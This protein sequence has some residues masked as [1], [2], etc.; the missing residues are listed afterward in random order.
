MKD[1]RS[2]P[3]A[4]TAAV[5]YPACGTTARAW[6]IFAGSAFAIA[7]AAFLVEATGLL[8][9]SPE[10]LPTGAG[11]VADEATFHAAAFTYAQQVL[12]GFVLRDGSYFFAYLALIP[13][14]LG[15]REVAGRRGVAPQLAAAFLG[16]AA[17]FGCRAARSILRSRR[18]ANSS[19]MA[20]ASALQ[21][22]TLVDART[23]R[24]TSMTTVSGVGQRASSSAVR[25]LSSISQA[26]SRV[27]KAEWRMRNGSVHDRIRRLTSPTL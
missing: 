21:A 7:T 22:A 10:Y 25:S 27:W 9:S 6:G 26:W 17:I 13:L 1:L 19:V 8:A 18:C 11:Q 24:I 23:K 14:G 3:A 12:W 2:M 4:S 5:L 20:D 16:V 15:L